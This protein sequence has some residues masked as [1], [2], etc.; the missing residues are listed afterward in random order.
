MCKNI[1][2]PEDYEY[3]YE[4]NTQREAEKKLGMDNRQINSVLKNRRDS[5]SGFTFEYV[6]DRDGEYNE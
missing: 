6:F 5:V 4:F 3:E 1:N 2:I